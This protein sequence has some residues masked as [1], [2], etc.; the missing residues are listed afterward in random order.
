[1][2]I[3][4]F[5]SCFLA[6]F[7]PW[8]PFFLVSW[9]RM[10][11][12]GFMYQKGIAKVSLR[13]SLWD[14][15]KCGKKRTIPSFARK[16]EWTNCISRHCKVSLLVVHHIA[17]RGLEPLSRKKSASQED[18]YMKSLAGF[19]DVD[20]FFVCCLF[21][22]CCL[23]IGDCWF[24]CWLSL[25]W[26]SSSSSLFLLLQCCCHCCWIFYLFCLKNDWLCAYIYTAKLINILSTNKLYWK[27]TSGKENHTYLPTSDTT[28]TYR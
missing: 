5:N 20:L 18:S 19:S 13:V 28:R 25:S 12:W 6:S 24:V 4:A 2:A 22:V 7:G 1:M 11:F 27:I 21:V 15:R 17:F 9:D 26:S 23:L 10:D 16:R 3:W 8:F 14:W